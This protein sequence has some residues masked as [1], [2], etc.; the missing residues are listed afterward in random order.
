VESN[1]SVW[2]SVKY[3][4]IDLTTSGN[5]TLLV[6]FPLVSSVLKSSPV[7]FF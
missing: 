2:G 1:Q 5:D 4:I 7:R 6:V 3:T